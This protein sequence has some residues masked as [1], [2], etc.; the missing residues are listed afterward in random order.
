MID[1]PLAVKQLGNG[2][3][4]DQDENGGD[5]KRQAFADKKIQGQTGNDEN[6]RDFNGHCGMVLPR[7]PGMVYAVRS[8][9]AQRPDMPLYCLRGRAASTG[10]PVVPAC[11]GID[12]LRPAPS[13]RPI[14][15]RRISLVPAPMSYSLA[16]RK[17]RPV[18]YSLIWPVPPR[19]C[20]ASS[21]TSTAFLEAW[22]M[23]AA[24]S[25]LECSL[26]S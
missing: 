17:R 2:R 10:R 12:Q 11:D 1:Q 25:I 7:P 6:Q 4:H 19:A 20:I 18:G 22:R 3:H 13:S 24:G 21:A 5:I 8:N 16:S 23:Q 14:S 9:A 26:R 15:M